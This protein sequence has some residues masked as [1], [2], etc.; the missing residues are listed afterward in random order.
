MLQM[1]NVF[2]AVKMVIRTT[3]LRM[4]EFFQILKHPFPIKATQL[5]ELKE[6]K[7]SVGALRL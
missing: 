4:E 5:L 2:A 1:F 3:C 7:Y 6:E